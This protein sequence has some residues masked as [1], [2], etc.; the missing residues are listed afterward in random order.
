[1]GVEKELRLSACD[2][3]MGAVLAEVEELLAQASC[4]E[5]AKMQIM[6]AA[7]ELFV[8]IRRKAGRGSPYDGDSAESGEVPHDFPGQRHTLQSAGA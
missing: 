1:M 3:N 4:D 8:N 5:T 6:M 7:E 2:E